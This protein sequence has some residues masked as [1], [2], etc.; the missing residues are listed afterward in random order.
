[1]WDDNRASVDLIGFKRY[2]EVVARL[3]LNDRLLPLTIGIYGEWGSGKSTVM[4][5]AEQRLVKEQGVVCTTFNG[6]MYQGY[7]ETK[8]ALM[9]KI[10]ETLKAKRGLTSKALDKADELLKKVNWFRLTAMGLRHLVMPLA[11]SHVTGMPPELIVPSAGDIGSIVTTTEDSPSAIQTIEGFPAQF[12]ELLEAAGVKTL[13]VFV[14]DLDRCL[15]VVVV[16]VLEAIKLFLSVEGT[17][18]VIGADKNTIKQAVAIRYPQGQ[19]VEAVSK[20]YLEKIVQ[21][22][23]HLH[24]LGEA[25]AETYLNLLFA[26]LHQTSSEFELLAEVATANRTRSPLRVALDFA[27]IKSSLGDKL[28]PEYVRDLGLVARIAPIIC[29]HERGNPRQLKR[30]LNTLL[31]REQLAAAHGLEVDVQVL[32]KLMI[33]EYY[34]T[35]PHYRQLFEWQL[36]G[37]GM[38]RELA[39]LEVMARATTQDVA[40]D[41][42]PVE[43]R[44]AGLAAGVTE[45]WLK[46]DD[47]RRWLRIDPS[48]GSKNLEPYFFVA[49]ERLAK[50]GFEA[51]DLSRDVREILSLLLSDDGVERER[52]KVLALKLTDTEAEALFSTACGRIAQVSDPSAYIAVLCDIAEQKSVLIP[53]LIGGLPQVPDDVLPTSAPNRVR[54]LGIM[55]PAYESSVVSFLK[56]LAN[57]TNPMIRKAAGAALAAGRGEG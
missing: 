45:G 8:A 31:L 15:P 20:I 36:A 44:Q 52:G 42:V 30:F 41:E 51:S 28:K 38:A 33:L 56:G 55:H 49:R 50:Y 27:A 19:D 29:R 48:L 35:D 12:R 5:L 21:V 16:D 2:A 43:G 39:T 17:A 6:W 11:A 25:E 40:P 24:A 22:P 26:Q 18:F 1:M 46:N 13:V 34:H 14:D 10:I 57:S 37:G 3:V 7:D 47:V 23:V 4:W 9:T 32:S 53:L 54:T